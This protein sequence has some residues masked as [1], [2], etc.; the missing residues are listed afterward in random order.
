MVESSLFLLVLVIIVSL[1]FDYING[2]SDTAN[3]IATCIATRALSVRSAV[4]MAAV[5]NFI[6]A[7]VSTKVAATIGEGIVDP[8]NITQ[9]VILTGVIGAISWG[10][11]TWFFSIPSSSSHAIIGGIIG[12][13][14][15]HSHF[16]ELK[17]MGIKKIILALVISPTLGSCL[18]VIV[19]KSTI[20][21]KH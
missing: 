12:A 18:T 8:Y 1:I 15:A 9:L 7:M 16:S 10:L 21:N 17:W 4:L 2:F 6:G 3:S 14:V 13:V 11:I 20:E 19:C 5:L